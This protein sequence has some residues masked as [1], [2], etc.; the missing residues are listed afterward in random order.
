MNNG[1]KIFVAI[2]VAW[3][4]IN[5]SFA[6]TWAVT[7]TTSTWNTMTWVVSTW[8]LINTWNTISPLKI[9]W[10]DFLDNKTLSIKL[11]N[12]LEWI[13]KDS[14]VKI[15]EDLSVAS[16]V[17]DIDNAKKV[18]V[19]LT[20]DLITWSSYS[21]VSVSEWVDSSID[22]TLWD[23]KTKILN[24]EFDK[25]ATSIEYISVLDNKTIEVY[26]NKDIKA[27][28]VEFKM[29]KEL[30]VE[31]TF[32]DTTNLN[33]KLLDNLASKNDYIAILSLK[34]LNSKDIEIVNSLYDFV[35]PEFPEVKVETNTWAIDTLSGSSLTWTTL[36]WATTWSW[37]EEL[38]MAA[39]NTPDTW[40]K[41][42]IL[43]FMTLLLTLG[44]FVFRKNAVKN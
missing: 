33:V 11:S 36:S 6:S 37:V 28:S 25:N 17:K 24:P 34:D 38:A 23:N 43:I 20:S 8:A 12:Q 21:L 39:K 13:S 42:N 31:N 41:T 30:K 5:L 18:K 14:E 19:T 4:W 9:D 1:K 27:T 35:T 16:S 10:I 44:L 32:L 3:L 22:F 40:A 29:F 15:L 2:M 26:F 7:S